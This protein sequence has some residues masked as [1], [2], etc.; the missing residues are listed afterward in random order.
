MINLKKLRNNR[1]LSINISLLSGLIKGGRALVLSEPIDYIGD[2][3]Q[4]LGGVPFYITDFFD[5]VIAENEKSAQCLPWADIVFYQD[6]SAYCNYQMKL[7]SYAKYKNSLLCT[8]FNAISQIK[9]L[10][11]TLK[12]CNI[13]YLASNEEY[14]LSPLSVR[15][16]KC[17]L[18]SVQPGVHLA[19]IMGCEEVFYNP[20]N[21]DDFVSAKKPRAI[22]PVN[23]VRPNRRPIIHTHL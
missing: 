9:K 16:V 2:T 18:S 20:S 11:R 15:G 13:N 10:N 3:L 19:K 5:I 7:E 4:E 21:L 23:L 1:S 12:I 22:I 14:E 8:N 17:G 6:D